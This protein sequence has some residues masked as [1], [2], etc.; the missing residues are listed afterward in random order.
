[1]GEDGIHFR[2]LRRKGTHGIGSRRIPGKEKGLA[3]AAAEI[4]FAAV[5][6]LAGLLHP[7]FTAEFLKRF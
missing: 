3:A 7:F 1:L 5:A 4:L 6:T 2:S